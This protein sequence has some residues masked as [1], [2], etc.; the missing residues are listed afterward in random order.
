MEELNKPV[1]NPQGP[2]KIK[3]KYK[4]IACYIQ[5]QSINEYEFDIRIKTNKKLD[6]SDLNG[7]K[8]YLEA[9]G[10]TNEATKH[11]LFW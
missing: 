2:Y 8:E 6:Q 9:E 7:L 11:N 3:L 4:G 10:F 1:T 5:M